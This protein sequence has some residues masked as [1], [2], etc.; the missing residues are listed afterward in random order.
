MSAEEDSYERNVGMVRVPDQPQDREHKEEEDR[1]SVTITEIEDV[2]HPADSVCVRTD[3]D[4]QIHD[5]DVSCTS[6]T[7]YSDVDDSLE[8]DELGSWSNDLDLPVSLQQNFDNGVSLP[9]SEAPTFGDVCVKN[10]SNVHFGNKT[11]YNGPVTIKQIVYSNP[12]VEGEKNSEDCNNKI[13]KQS[14]ERNESQSSQEF[15]KGEY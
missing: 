11:F 2:D 1:T 5:E 10:S 3:S 6:S 15:R 9:V 12:T 4:V 7:Q 13:D 8:G 14:K